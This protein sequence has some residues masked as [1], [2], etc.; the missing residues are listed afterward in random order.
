VSEHD[1]LGPIDYLAVEFPTGRMTGSG[2]RL[3]R[4]VVDRGLVLVMDLEFVR[5]GIDGTVTRVPLEAVPQENPA[6]VSDWA[7]SYS[8]LLDE[9]DLKEV[10]AAIAPG[11]LAGVLVYENLWAA[12]VLQQISDSGAVLLA[13][14]RIDAGDVMAALELNAAG[15]LQPRVA[16]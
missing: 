15:K 1:V 13:T 8:G 14:G 7:G 5:K 3:L 6:E 4:D 10:S 12:P 2:F 9:D 16:D 11:S